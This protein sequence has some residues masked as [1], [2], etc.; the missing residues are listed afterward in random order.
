[1]AFNRQ[2]ASH[3][4][5]NSVEADILVH[6]SDLVDDEALASFRQKEYI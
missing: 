5:A 2:K 1:M 4:G 3:T 6:C